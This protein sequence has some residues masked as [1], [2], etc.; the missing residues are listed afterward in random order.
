M[1]NQ[2]IPIRY[3]KSCIHPHPSP[4]DMVSVPI[5]PRSIWLPSPSITATL[6]SIPQNS[7]FCTSADKLFSHC[8]E[9]CPIYH[10]KWHYVLGTHLQCNISYFRFHCRRDFWIF[11][12]RFIIFCF[13]YH[14]NTVLNTTIP[15]PQSL[16]PLP[17]Y[18]HSSCF[19]YRG[20]S[21]VTAVLPLSP[22]LCRSLDCMSVR[23]VLT[24]VQHG[25]HQL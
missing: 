7:V 5:R 9:T 3:R 10:G 21:A 22:L 25:R 8:L 6:F 18:Y 19:H 12:T 13:R 1:E 24:W 14:G 16:S 17:R 4:S 23:R 11:V 20:K 15:L 2:A